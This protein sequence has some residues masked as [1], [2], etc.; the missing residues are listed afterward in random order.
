MAETS[1]RVKLLETCTSSNMEV[2]GMFIE[3]E[4]VKFKLAVV[5]RPPPSSE[6]RPVAG[7][8]LSAARLC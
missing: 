5:Y 7:F 2:M 6:K 3:A 1:L 4:A 8:F